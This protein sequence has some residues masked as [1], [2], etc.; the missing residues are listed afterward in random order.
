MS[1][2]LKTYRVTVIEWLSHKAV[3]EAEGPEQ[4]E[5]KARELWANN[6]EHAVFAFEDS[7][8]DGVMVDE[9]RPMKDSHIT[10]RARPGLSAMKFSIHQESDDYVVLS[11]DGFEVHVFAEEGVLCAQIG[12]NGIVRAATDF[13]FDEQPEPSFWGDPSENA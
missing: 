9:A 1:A 10:P 3:I 11:I 6:A 5:V 7:G 12:K 8:I 2:S 4:A 13:G